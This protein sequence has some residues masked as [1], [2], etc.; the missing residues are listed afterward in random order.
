MFEAV[1]MD[2]SVNKNVL[3]T[4]KKIIKNQDELNVTVEKTSEGATIIDVGIDAQGG[5]AAGKYVTEVCMGGL[6]EASLSIMDFDDLYIP[7]ISVVTDFPTI[8]LLGA[9][10]AGWRVSV[11]KYF[12]MGSGP[13]SEKP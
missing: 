12:A 1:K 6:G 13:A 3:T 11:G 2:V 4:V 9:Q 5:Y 10:F 7:A 8:A